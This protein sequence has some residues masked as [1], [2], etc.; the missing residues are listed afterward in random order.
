LPLAASCLV[1]LG[2]RALVGGRAQVRLEDV[3]VGQVDDGLFDLARQ[4]ALGL[5]HE[6]LVEGVLAADQHRPALARAPGAPPALPE[7]GH[8]A[9]KAGDQGHVETAH[10]DAELE[11][12]GRHHGAQLPV[13]QPAFYVA[14]L[15]R[16]VAGA[17]GHD[18]L[19]G[20]AVAVADTP[21]H[22][23]V[24]E[25][26]RLARRGEVDGA[27]PGQHGL[28]EHV[29][30]LGKGALAHA[31]GDVDEG[32]VPEHDR[33]LRSRRAVVVDGGERQADEA[34]GEGLRVGDRGRGEHELGPRTVGL[35]EPAQAAH[36]LRH[37]RAEHAAVHVG[38][39]EHDVAQVV[40]ELGPAFVARQDAG[41]Q[42]VGV[43]QQDG[44]AVAYAGALRAR[45]VAV[46]E[47][48]DRPRQ[49]QRGELARLVLGERLGGVEEE[50]PAVGV[51][52]EGVE[53]GQ[54]EG[55]R[56]AAGGARGHDHV[57]A[58]GQ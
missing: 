26:G 29:A 40:Q 54:R 23:A 17:V 55:Q 11:R 22:V 44:G 15:L 18:G 58:L 37:V 36:H 28:G 53:R 41:V 42:H 43:G 50:R 13:E 9:G 8:G 31:Q 10:V 19:G 48:G 30:R 39:V 46:V 7:A 33:L 1:A 6:V 34:L 52:G 14:A 56:L 38:L 3:R 25:L 24:D 32:R 35:A 45:R 16:G 2:Q 5:A 49:A 51:V 47:R 4:Q 12:A 57:A 27:P 20:R 21:P